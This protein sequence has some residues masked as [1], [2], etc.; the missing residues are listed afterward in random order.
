M[1][2]SQPKPWMKI[3]DLQ[4]TEGQRSRRENLGEDDMVHGRA[5]IQSETWH[6]K[7]VQDKSIF[8]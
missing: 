4:D 1:W 3:P 6:Q 7:T 2:D 8:R 5:D